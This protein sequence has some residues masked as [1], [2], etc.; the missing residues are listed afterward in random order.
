[1]LSP[2]RY[3]L[4]F[5]MMMLS[6]GMTAQNTL[7]DIIYCLNGG[8]NKSVGISKLPSPNPPGKPGWNLIFSDEFQSD[9]LSPA[10]WNHS[11]PW[12]D[13]NGSCVRS[14]AFNPENAAIENG[15]A[16]IINTAD[17]YL[18]GCQY[19]GGEIK[20]MSVRDSAFSSY[21][22]YAPGYLETRVK[23]FNK[24]GQGAACWLWA[25]GTPE[26]PGLSGPW[27]EIDLFEINGVNNNIFTGTYHWTYN[28]VHVSQ[29]HNVY[30]TDST[31]Q[32]D[33]E[34]NWTTFGLEWDTASVKWY[35]NNVLVKELDF[36]LIPPFCIPAAHYSI[37]LSPFCIRFSTSSNTVGNQS[38]VAT[39]ADFPQSML[40]D[41]VRVYKKSG[42]KAA[43]IMMQ[44]GRY[45][46]CSTAI[47]PATSAKI[48]RTRYY[49][50]ATYEWSS[51]AFEM[52]KV[53]SPV[54]Q[55]PEQMLLWIKPGITAGQT[56][57]VYLKAIF[58]ANYTEYDTADI[59]IASEIP[60]LPPD[61]FVPAQIDSLCYFSIS[62]PVAP[63][64]AACEY[65]L[66][67]GI[68]WLNGDISTT[69]GVDTCSFGMFK[70]DEHVEFA[71]REQNGCGWSPVR[72]SEMTM[73]AAPAGCK[74]HA[75]APDP[76]SFNGTVSFSPNP[77]ADMMTIRVPA[78]LHP[79]KNEV[80]LIMYDLN[81]RVVLHKTL[82]GTENHLDLGFLHHGIYYFQVIRNG[83]IIFKST[84]IKS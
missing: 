60:G 41:Y 80:H 54:P 36:S 23:L 82:P 43:P 50:D 31:Q 11:T 3:L 17:T 46:I 9:S 66:D 52:E 53:I 12:D 5:A 63:H 76:P 72:F 33:L 42:Q 8:E 26:N 37:P 29:N 78:S 74:W 10:R 51:P 25:V 65:S 1:M 61:N 62:A 81:G 6:A 20:T 13:G 22:F 84:F 18:P 44:D 19:S 14:F 15:N 83:T 30:L 71:F 59:F 27:N 38:V 73:P 64:T 32:Y 68:N 40:V 57:P 47:S 35:V 21:Y 48:I 39:P 58:P 75:G 24:T 69:D 34:T 28:N 56:Y 79:A 45:Q 2:L 67:N 55:P 7:F 70:P 77:V 4:F 16:R 49:P